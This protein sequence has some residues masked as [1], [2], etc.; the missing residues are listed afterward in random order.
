MMSTIIYYNII[1]WE[2]FSNSTT[3]FTQ[4]TLTHRE[5]QQIVHYMPLC[6]PLRPQLVGLPTWK[7]QHKKK[8][9]TLRSSLTMNSFCAFFFFFSISSSFVLHYPNSVMT[10]FVKE[11]QTP[12]C[13]AV[14]LAAWQFEELPALSECLERQRC[15]AK[16]QNTSRVR[17]RAG[18]NDNGNDSD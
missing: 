10:T 1:E 7:Y 6:L 9:P 4:K 3:E 12:I 2:K 8:S 18:V 11:T 16:K 13:I 17:N 15:R 5:S 14:Y